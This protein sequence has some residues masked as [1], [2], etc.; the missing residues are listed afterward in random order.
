MS[1]MDR[2]VEDPCS[3]IVSARLNRR[4]WEKLKH[5]TETTGMSLSAVVRE[6]IN[7]VMVESGHS[8]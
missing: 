2:N 8:C 6:L 3:Y 7:K 5:L 4:E 1:A